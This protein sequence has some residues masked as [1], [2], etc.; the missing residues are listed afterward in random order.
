MMELKMTPFSIPEA[1]SFNYE[2]LKTAITQKTALYETVVYTED[3]VKKAKEDRASLNRL[4]KALNDERIRQEREYMQPFN[5]FKGQINEIIAII[6]KP[7]AAIDTQVKEFEE[8]QKEAKFAQ[9]EDFFNACELPAPV[10]LLQ[11]MDSKWLNASVAMKSIQEAITSRLEQMESDL[12]AIRQ[13]PAYAFEAEQTYLINFDLAQAIK[14]A[15][16]LQEMADRKA[17]YE[18]D[19]QRRI[20]EQETRIRVSGEMREIPVEPAD[21]PT[22]PKRELPEREW[23]AFQAYLTPDEAKAL[24]N[25]MKS[26]GINYKAV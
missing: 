18:A 8:Q 12:A 6:K 11:I 7:I 24:G 3:Q 20:A 2:E 15:H 10:K 26:N 5:A 25:Y 16:R 1:P 23:I 17:A 13:L 14:E 21:I 9:I 19:V 4:L 22:E